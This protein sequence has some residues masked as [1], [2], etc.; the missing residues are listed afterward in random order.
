MTVVTGDEDFSRT[1]TYSDACA[2]NIA[3]ELGADFTADCGRVHED[4][5]ANQP[6]KWMLLTG[7]VASVIQRRKITPEVGLT[8]D[9]NQ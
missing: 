4:R 9:V 7:H 3:I 2:G 5:H 1:P 8:V 6:K